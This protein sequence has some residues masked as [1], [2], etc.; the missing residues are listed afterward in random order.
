MVGLIP[1]NEAEQEIWVKIISQDNSEILPADLELMILDDQGE[2]IMTTDTQ[3]TSS[4]L[5]K[6]TGDKDEKFSIKVLL[7]GESQ[8]STF[9]I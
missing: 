9:I 5:L 4:I 3:E 1:R 7:A 6:F 2:V 8:T